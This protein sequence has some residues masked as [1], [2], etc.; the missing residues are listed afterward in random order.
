MLDSSPLPVLLVAEDGRLHYVNQA[1]EKL[2]GH[3]CQ[4]LAGMTI[5]DI[6][7]HRRP[8]MWRN[9]LI[10]LSQSGSRTLTSDWRAADGR[11]IPVELHASYLEHEAKRYVVLYAHDTSGRRAEQDQSFRLAHSD[12]MT[13]LP[14]SQMLQE[15]LQTEARLAISQGR[16]I[17]LV[18]VEIHEIRKINE[19][20]GYAMGDQ[21]LLELTRKM[22]AGLRKSDTLTHMGSGEFMLLLVGDGQ[23]DDEL[24]LQFSRRLVQ[25]LS[26]PIQ[27]EGAVV[28]VSCNIGIVVFP[29]DGDE[30]P[31][32]ALRQ[33][34][35]AMRMAQSIGPNQICFYT[36]EANDKLGDKLARAAALRQ[37]LDRQELY[38]QY[39]PQLD[40][41][42]G[43]VIGA[44]ALVRWCSERFG[45]LPPEDFIPI[46]EE[47]EQLILKISTWV[48]T[49]ACESAVKWQQSGLPALRM[50]VNMSSRQLSQPDIARAIEGVLRRTGL[51]PHCLSIEVAESTLMNDLDR[52]AE[53]LCE[54]K[55]IGVHIA[56]DEFGTG[57]SSLTNLRRLPIDLIKIGRALVPDV[58]AAT[59]DVSIARAIINLAHSLQ[60]KVMAVGVESEGELAMLV[61]NQCD[62]MQ[63]FYFSEP[64]H[65]PDMMALLHAKKCLPQEALGRK[66]H[67]RTLL[68]V[69]DEESIVSSLKRLLRRDGYD[70][71]TAN[72]GPQGLQRL[73]EHEVDVILSDQR[74]PG[75]MGV[76]FLRRAKELYPKTVR[77]VLSGYTELQSITDAIN[78]GAIY[79][80]L[81]KP[82]NDELVRGHI[83]EAFQQKEM[84]DENLRLDREVQDAN[85]ELAE[86]NKRLQ[87]LL[88]Y[89]QEHINRE[90][91]SLSMARNVLENIP[92]P[93][94][95]FDPEG[96]V[97]FMNSD[98]E[99]LF[100]D[101]G[102]LLGM[103]VND[104]D[105]AP[106]AMLWQDCDG[107]QHDIELKGLPFR[108]VCRAMTGAAQS[109][110]A[111][112]VL[113]PQAAAT[114]P[115][116]PTESPT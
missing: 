81:T 82:W 63:G 113:M 7:P 104:L 23:L 18:A 114:R 19:S 32:Q 43:Q 24:A 6:A 21:L 15:R 59:H 45:D 3:A 71:I 68:L 103:H 79:K 106:L 72:S 107:L 75:M 34:Q 70:I 99:E 110:G 52:T 67:K 64:L 96:M 37:A 74:M 35:A 90:E 44:E 49:R 10:M 51:D 46:A 16:Q 38:L 61:A 93:L 78:E 22:A 2:L 20:L 86:V 101:A 53:T 116:C 109:R 56:L 76:D 94:I 97:A 54:L 69:D 98:A 41:V 60:K 100:S 5:F 88:A 13:G 36:A 25:A 48:L 65:E 80:F 112:M 55:S 102:G 4:V 42:T 14:S 66:G 91:T 1:A 17:A 57:Y 9:I 77:M 29:Q 85:L 31:R 89:Q 50:A 58:M 83:K 11:T 108:A 62:Q 33:A 26:G 8:D 87:H 40:L 47:A 30:E 111:L 12:T 84:A 27:L 28:E 39:Q 115:I 95:G 105:L 73:A 92:A